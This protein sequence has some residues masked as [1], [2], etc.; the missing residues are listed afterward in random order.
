[1]VSRETV[2][3][4]EPARLPV[5]SCILAVERTRITAGVAVREGNVLRLNIGGGVKRLPGWTNVDIAPRDGVDIVA[6]A[7]AIPLP[8]G[9]AREIMA[10]HL[11]EHFYVWEV[12]EVLRE[13]HR[14][15]RSGGELVLELP[16][17]MKA[18]HNILEGRAEKKP[19]QLG[20]WALYGDPTTRDP[21]M[22]HKWA[23]T[24]TT[25]TPVLR[26]VGFDRVALRETRFHPAGRGIRDFRI[27][28]LR[29]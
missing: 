1:M 22:C 20:M 8:D 14:L 2:Y 9:C 19:G 26:E 29:P 15:L 7:R 21:L 12:P 24:P 6:D 18:L 23:W 11:L 10:I 13:W 17:M 16:D 27:E 4:R 25:L 3:P 5:P 28:A